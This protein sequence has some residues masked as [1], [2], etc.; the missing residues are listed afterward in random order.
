MQRHPKKGREKVPIFFWEVLPFSSPSSWCCHPPSEWCCFSPSSFWVVVLFALSPSGR[1]CC[2][3][4]KQH[5]PKEKK[6]PA[7]PKEGAVQAA[8]P[9]R[10]EGGESISTRTWRRKHHQRGEGDSSTAHQ[11]EGNATPLK[12]RTEGLY[13]FWEVLPFSSPSWWCHPLLFWSGVAFVVVLF[14]LSPVGRCCCVFG[15]A[16]PPSEGGEETQQ[17]Q[18][19]E[20]AKQHHPKEAREEKTQHTS[21][22][23]KAARPIQEM[24][25]SSTT[26]RATT[27]LCSALCFS[28]SVNLN[29]P[30]SFY[31]CYL[32]FFLIFSFFFHSVLGIALMWTTCT[33]ESQITALMMTSWT[34]PLFASCGVGDWWL[35]VS[36]H[37]CFRAFLVLPCARFPC[38]S[39]FCDQDEA[40]SLGQSQ[41]GCQMTEVSCACCIACDRYPIIVVNDASWSWRHSKVQSHLVVCTR[42]RCCLPLSF[43]TPVVHFFLFSFFFLPFF[44]MSL[45]PFVM[46]PL[47][48][49]LYLGSPLYTL[50]LLI[51]CTPLHPSVPFCSAYSVLFTFSLVSNCFIFYILHFFFFISGTFL[52]LFVLL[53]L[54]LIFT[55]SFTLAIPVTSTHHKYIW[56]HIDIHHFSYCYRHSSVLCCTLLYLVFTFYPS[57]FVLTFTFTSRLL[58]ST[59][60]L[61][62][63]CLLFYL[64]H[65]VTVILL[66]YITITITTTITFTSHLQIQYLGTWRSWMYDFTCLTWWRPPKWLRSLRLRVLCV[67]AC[68]LSEVTCVVSVIFCK[69]TSGSWIVSC[70]VTI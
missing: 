15:E 35:V 16:A 63:Y 47:S 54:P 52:Q 50:V 20:E 24:A 11:G 69:V 22:M 46:W 30:S 21:W 18:K 14:S 19:K 64:S 13:F 55:I 10:G 61:T 53:L 62:F 49:V 23:E 38:C 8:P 65:D 6:D 28:T 45:C 31:F 58:F 40:L 33:T 41:H 57:S 12:K 48:F 29:L 2:F 25:E 4:A 56:Q 51:R 27:L 17:H 42:L 39:G 9:E 32:S 66:H 70:L 36:P 7:P 34:C 43:L 3:T 5:H 60:L 59:S 67:C 44:P 68:D 1:C 26:Q 37:A